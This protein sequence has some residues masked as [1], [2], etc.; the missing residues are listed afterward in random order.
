MK[1]SGDHSFNAPRDRVWEALLDPH[2]LVN[3]LPGAE[4]LEEVGENRFAGALN[5]QVGPVSGKF[6]GEVELYDLEPEE[7]YKLKMSGKGA[8]GFVNGTGAIRLADAE[9]GGTKLSYQVDMQVGGRIASV[10]QRLLES[11]G[12][13]LT[14]QALEGLEQ[15]IEARERPPAAKPTPAAEPDPAKPAAATPAAATP[16]PEPAAPRRVARPTTQA[17]SQ[18]EFAARFAKGMFEEYV[19]EQKRPWVLLGGVLSLLLAV[20][21]LGRASKP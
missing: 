10:G 1:L 17:P 20:F 7:G 12:R 3:T 21:L 8:P 19:P 4:K 2:V 14:R 13:V 9:G 16:T 18:V 15:Q 11:S 5:M 6:D